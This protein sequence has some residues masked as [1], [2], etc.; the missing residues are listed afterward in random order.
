MNMTKLERVVDAR[1]AEIESLTQEEERLEESILTAEDA[2]NYAASDGNRQEY[3]TQKTKIKDTKEQLEFLKIRIKALKENPAVTAEEAQDAW[4]A[5]ISGYDREMQK[6][7]AKYQEA[8]KAL[9]AQY[10]TLL[11]LQA[12]MIRKRDKLAALTG[13]E[14]FKAKAIYPAATLPNRTA[15]DMPLAI[16]N[17]GG[18]TLKDPDAVFFMADHAANVGLGLPGTD[19]FSEYMERV[20][21]SQTFTGATY[22][23]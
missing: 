8:K 7:M 3:D 12:E 11:D 23:R 21:G 9:L 1:K 5:F 13:T 14:Y 20:V 22:N 15:S 4:S 19:P 10:K 2:A 6:G 16:V 18:T 17:M